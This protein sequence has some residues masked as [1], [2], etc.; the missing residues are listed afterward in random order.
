MTRP[1][2]ASAYRPDIDG[3]R[4]VAVGAVLVFHAFLRQHFGGFV[5]VD[6][7]F[8]ISGYLITGILVREMD[9]G[10]FTFAGF[11]AR[12]VRRIYPA[13]VVVL[14]LTLLFGWVNLFNEDFRKLALHAASAAGFVINL[15]LYGEAGYFDTASD[16]KPLLHLWS[17]GVEEQFYILWPVILLVAHKAARRW[18]KPLVAIALGVLL[19]ASFADAARLMRHDISAAFFL[20]LPRGWELLAGAGLALAHARGVARQPSPRIAAALGLAGAALVAATLVLI[21]PDRPFPGWSA[22]PPVLGAAL[23][24]AAGPAGW[25]NRVVMALPPL[26]W[27]GQIS[28]PL[29]LW[30]WPLLAFAAIAGF[31]SLAARAVCVALALVLAWATVRL[32]ERPLRFGGGAGGKLAGLLAV[33]T[34]LGLFGLWAWHHRL[35]SYTGDTTAALSRQLNWQTPVGSNAQKAACYRLMPDRVGMAHPVQND[36]CYLLHDGQPDV[37][38]VGDSLNLSLF[39]GMAHVT[40]HN[41]L[42][43]SASEAA[44]F[45]DSRTTDLPDH[46]RLNNYRLTNQALDYAIHTRSVKVVLLSYLNADRLFTPAS[47]HYIQDMRGVDVDSDVPA[48]PAIDGPATMAMMMRRTL[49]RLAAAGK[50]VIVILPNRRMSFNPASCLDTLRP[51][52]AMGDGRPCAVPVNDEHALRRAAYIERVRAIA[53]PFRNV[54]LF[55]ASQALCDQRLCYAMRDGK[56]LYRDDLHVSEQGAAVVAPGLEQ[57]IDTAMGRAGAR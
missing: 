32:V 5:G 15:V 45:W 49:A 50:K 57:A 22:I 27:L 21:T 39:P 3:L 29:Y 25:F 14:G 2:A 31:D 26:R 48:N 44:P 41:L 19:L 46:S 23:L 17:L 36:F 1:H 53:R 20:P 38:M 55:D 30:H 10:A 11:Y 12:R 16:A 18:N 33:M 42:L 43:A 6:I 28:Y 8:V 9:E 54:S 40:K 47:G 51:V 34:A 35:A 37:A 52:H 7:F 56:M 13:L 24:I 4:A